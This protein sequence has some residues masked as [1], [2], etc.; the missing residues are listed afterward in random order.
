[1]EYKAFSKHVGLSEKLNR[2][3]YGSGV[4]GNKQKLIPE[5]K[6]A[7]G[8]GKKETK[9]KIES[10]TT[11]GDDPFERKEELNVRIMEMILEVTKTGHDALEFAQDN[12]IFTRFLYGV[13]NPDNLYGE[14]Y[15]RIVYIYGSYHK[16]E[17]HAAS[18]FVHEITHAKINE[19]MSIRQEALCRIEEARFIHELKGGNLTIS[20]I[21]SIIKEIHEIDVYNEYPWRNK[22]GQGKIN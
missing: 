17:L 19:P 1:M 21:R 14:Y 5:K 18:T 9:A 15:D 13:G 16:D 20:E 6:P 22:S 3:G 12:N 11:F 4:P 8:Q 10:G 2:T 7:I